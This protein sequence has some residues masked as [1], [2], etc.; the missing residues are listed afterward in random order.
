MARKSM[1]SRA[2][3]RRHNISLKPVSRSRGEK[4]A[5]NQKRSFSNLVEVLIDNEWERLFGKRA[6]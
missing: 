5:S 6:A 3:S 4:L 1:G 2:A